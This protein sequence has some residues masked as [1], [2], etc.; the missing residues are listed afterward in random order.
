MKNIIILWILFYFLTSFNWVYANQIYKIGEDSNERNYDLLQYCSDIYYKENITKYNNETIKNTLTRIKYW[1]KVYKYVKNK[2]KYDFNNQKAEDFRNNVYKILIK[3]IN[4]K[5]IFWKNQDTLKKELIYTLFL[6]WIDDYL[7]EKNSTIFLSNNLC[8][9]IKDWNWDKYYFLKEIDKSFDDN[10][11]NLYKKLYW[12]NNK[13]FKNEIKEF[14]DVFINNKNNFFDD[15]EKNINKVLKE[16]FKKINNSPLSKWYRNYL[17]EWTITVWS[18]AI[19]FKKEKQLIDLKNKLLIRQESQEDYILELDS[20]EK[21][22]NFIKVLLFVDD[23]FEN[24]NFKWYD[25][26]YTAFKLYTI[27]N[28][29]K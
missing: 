25:K 27:E 16:F 9:K 6:I 23:L 11:N 26:Y 15:N 8:N 12:E 29:Y 1:D 22:E 20:P 14:Y 24:N 13:K 18:E 17:V 19:K 7:Y 10:Y 5:S 28:N 4:K 3:E 21:I 2:F